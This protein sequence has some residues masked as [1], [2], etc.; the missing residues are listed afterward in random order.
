MEDFVVVTA[1]GSLIILVSFFVR[2][3]TGF[4]TLPHLRGSVSGSP[5]LLLN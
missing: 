3:L 2:S 5:G 1:V 4:G